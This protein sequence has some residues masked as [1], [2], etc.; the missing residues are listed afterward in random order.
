M[1]SLLTGIIVGILLMGSVTFADNDI[2][3]S[4]V[5]DSTTDSDVVLTAVTDDDAYCSY[6]LKADDED[7][8]DENEDGD[9]DEDNEN[10]TS[11]PWTLM[12]NTSGTTH[13]QL[14]AGLSN[15][16]YEVHVKCCEADEINEGCED[17]GDNDHVEWDVN[18]VSV[19]EYPS[20]II[21]ALLSI[22]SFG[23]VSFKL[24]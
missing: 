6:K 3:T 4:P 21:P 2:I 8:D 15:G 22:A 12:Q 9:D 24:K 13:T 18:T 16:E 11:S 1:K 20:A 5:E 19:P 14:L 7:D 10:D 17:H 23:L